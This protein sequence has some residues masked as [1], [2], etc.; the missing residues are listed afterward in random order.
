MSVS[1][2]FIHQCYSIFEKL[3]FLV[4]KNEGYHQY[5]NNGCFLNVEIYLNF[6]SLKKLNINDFP[7]PNFTWGKIEMFY[8]FSEENYTE[9]T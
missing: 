8:S 1:H 3:R 7:S 5:F 9:V 2:F 4:A 6:L